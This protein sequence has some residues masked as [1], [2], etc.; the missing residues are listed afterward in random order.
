MLYTYTAK[1]DVTEIF[2]KFL[3]FLGKQGPRLRNSHE[4]IAQEWR[5]KF[6]LH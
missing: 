4:S 5:P 3:G 6:H 1:F 2:E